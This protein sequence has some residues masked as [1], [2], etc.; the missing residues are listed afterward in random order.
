MSDNPI[1]GLNGSE[2]SIEEIY[3]LGADAVILNDIRMAVN[4]CQ[5]LKKNENSGEK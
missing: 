1:S 4:Y 3:A 5:K 2:E